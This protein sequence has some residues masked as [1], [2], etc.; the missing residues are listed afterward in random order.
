MSI[1]VWR[2]QPRSAPLQPPEGWEAPEPWRQGLL[3]AREGI[4]CDQLWWRYIIRPI[5]KK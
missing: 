2:E 3:V 5:T 4:Q 1:C